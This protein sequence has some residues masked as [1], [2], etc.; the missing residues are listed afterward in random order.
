MGH[1]HVVAQQR[2]IYLAGVF[3]D[4]LVDAYAAARVDDP[5]FHPRLLPDDRNPREFLLFLTEL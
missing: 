4:G 5:F 1:L 3:G 2:F